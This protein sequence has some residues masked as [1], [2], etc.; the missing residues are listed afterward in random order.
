MEST[1]IKACIFDLDG[2]IVDT[3]HYHYLSWRKL[4][5]ILGFD[6]SP[7]E[8]ENL[9]GVSRRESLEYILKLGNKSL[10]EA[11]IQDYLVQKNEWYLSYIKEMTPEEIL[12]GVVSFLKELK[13][14]NIKAAIGSSSKN[15]RPILERVGLSDRFEVIV[16]GTNIEKGK[17]DPEVFQKAAK[18]LGLQPN[19]C[20]VVEDAIAGVEAALSGEFPVLAIGSAAGLEKATHLIA[21]TSDLDINLLS[22]F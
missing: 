2:V 16:D 4:A 5:N 13:K 19:E 11:E 6:L 9:K 1:N 3:A 7:N 18:G 12:P 22:K 17:P 10:S 14:N 20:L 15:A 21:S 8:N